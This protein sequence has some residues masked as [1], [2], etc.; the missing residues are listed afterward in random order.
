MFVAVLQIKNGTHLSGID[1][2]KMKGKV[3]V[4]QF[5]RKCVHYIQKNRRNIWLIYK[6]MK[7]IQM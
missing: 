1:G 4:L 3:C 5:Q 7:A 2:K 6:A